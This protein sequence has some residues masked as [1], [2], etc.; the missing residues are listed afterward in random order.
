M[1]GGLSIETEEVSKVPV[2]CRGSVSTGEAGGK[3]ICESVL[4]RCIEMVEDK[5]GRAGKG[6]RMSLGPLGP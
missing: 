1:G 5:L 4:R 6:S 2:V 3:G